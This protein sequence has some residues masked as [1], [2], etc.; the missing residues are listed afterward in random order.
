MLCT[1]A[2]MADFP[3]SGALEGAWFLGLASATP[4]PPTELLP[5]RS[6]ESLPQESEVG[7]FPLKLRF[8]DGE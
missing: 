2:R 3:L 7:M 4:E 5:P 1:S 6:R 8:L